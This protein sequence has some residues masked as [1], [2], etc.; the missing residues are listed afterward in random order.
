MGAG[1]ALGL[2]FGFGCK[3]DDTQGVAISSATAAITATENVEQALDGLLDAADFVADSGSLAATFGMFEGQSS[4]CGGALAPCDPLATSCPE[5]EITCERVADERSDLSQLRDELREAVDELVSELRTR[6]LTEENLESSTET[7][8]VYRLGPSVLCEDFDDRLERSDCADE[9][10]R[11]QPR[12]RLTSP[13]EGDI[14]VTFVVGLERNEPFQL[15]LYRTSLGVQVDLGELLAAARSMGE[16]IDA[17]DE[18]RGVVQAQLVKNGEMDFSVVLNLREAVEISARTDGDEP[19][20]ASLAASSPALELRADGLSETLRL[21]SDWRELSLSAPLASFGEFFEA[22]GD[23]ETV[24]SIDGEARPV[25]AEDGFA[26]PPPPESAEPGPDEPARSYTGVVDLFLAGLSSTLT[27]TADSDR[28]VYENIGYG[29][30]TSTVDHDGN[31]LVELDLN[32]SAGRRFAMVWE[33]LEAGGARVTITPSFE[34]R[35]KLALQAIA[36]QF[37]DLPEFLLDD[38]LTVSF[39]GEEP[40]LEIGE[41]GT[42]RV[43]AGVLVL[44]SATSPSATVEVAAGQCLIEAEAA[45]EEGHPWL[46]AFE[47]GSCE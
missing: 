28:L 2:A 21:A 16:E 34:L 6:V 40:A 1:C 42:S 29:D 39:Q 3:E 32:E 4:S 27:Y 7:S 30:A 22:L 15:Q 25:P 31:R 37:A 19:F 46:G 38:T 44:S 35:V 13:R 47:A 5:P 36:D 17:I 41:D 45:L 23:E 10:E 11:V 43:A 26:A 33:A 12:I 8:V 20:T 18:V 24:P 14:D 9:V